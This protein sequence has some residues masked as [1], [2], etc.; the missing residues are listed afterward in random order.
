MLCGLKTLVYEFTVRV[1][2]MGKTKL[3]FIMHADTHPIFLPVRVQTVVYCFNN[4]A[5]A[6]RT[7]TKS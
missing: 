3:I 7:G 5:P 6:Q 1:V 2:T 4:I